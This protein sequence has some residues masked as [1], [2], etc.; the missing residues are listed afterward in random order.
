MLPYAIGAAIGAIFV[1]RGRPKA[2]IRQY[3]A[4]GPRTGLAYPVEEVVEAGLIIV[5]APNAT[6]CFFRR[7]TGGFAFYRASGEP[8]AVELI[9][10]DFELPAGG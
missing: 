10:R 4:L 2:A 9:R 5:R 3:Q 1:A 8:K 6:V 7:K